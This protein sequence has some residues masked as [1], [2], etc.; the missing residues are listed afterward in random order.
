[1]VRVSVFSDSR[2][3]QNGSDLLSINQLEEKLLCRSHDASFG[4]ALRR[5][6][7]GSDLRDTENCL[8][9]ESR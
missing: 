9:N 4:V 6:R 8:V 3:S 5:A 2:V 1:M 7:L